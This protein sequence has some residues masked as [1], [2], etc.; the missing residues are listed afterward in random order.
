[1]EPSG[2]PMHV[3]L[4]TEVKSSMGVFS[5]TTRVSQLEQPL[6]S[7]AHS[8]LPAVAHKAS[9]SNSVMG[10]SSKVSDKSPVPPER[11]MTA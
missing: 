2:W 4:S 11:V 9:K 10:A 7:M 3:A 8:K 5:V 6:A 1:M